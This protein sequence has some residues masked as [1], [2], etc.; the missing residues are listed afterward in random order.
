[1]AEPVRAF[2]VC[3]DEREVHGVYLSREVAQARCDANNS[4]SWL[5]L[6]GRPTTDREII[7]ARPDDRL[8]EDRG[9]MKAGMLDQE[10]QRAWW[11]EHV[12]RNP[13]RE[14]MEDMRV[15]EVD[16]YG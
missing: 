10:I 14:E 6:D 3:S 15:E 2:M 7:A 4:E 5:L 1:M 8:A 9:W 12:S 13:A 16:F 11:S